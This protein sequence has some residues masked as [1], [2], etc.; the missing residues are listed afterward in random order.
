MT[1]E[2]NKER[3][4]AFCLQMLADEKRLPNAEECK[5]FFQHNENETLE[6]IT[7]YQHLKPLSELVVASVFNKAIAGS[8]THQKLW[9]QLVEQWAAPK[10]TIPAHP[11]TDESDSISINL[12]PFTSQLASNGN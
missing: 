12:K 2:T 4:A 6:P 8:V 1:T 7:P 5:S 10:P 11:E 3:L 9:F